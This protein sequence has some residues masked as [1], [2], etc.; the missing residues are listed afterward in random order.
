MGEQRMGRRDAL[1]MMGAAAVA[2]GVGG[3]SGCGVVAA[4]GRIVIDVAW[5]SLSRLVFAVF[6]F[7]EKILT[8]V[9]LADEAEKRLSASVNDDQAK[10]LKGGA[11]LYL[12]TADGKEHEILFR[13]DS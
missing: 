5:K 12:R 4:A 3:T 11:K 7:G 6:N 13:T 8:V 2:G 1:K 9:A 10:S